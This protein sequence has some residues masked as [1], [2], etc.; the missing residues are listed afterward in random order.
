MMDAKIN[1]RINKWLGWNK[2][3]D[4]VHSDH[5]CWKL[6]ETLT[7][8]GL[9]IHEISAFPAPSDALVQISGSVFY[10]GDDYDIWKLTDEDLPRG[11]TKGDFKLALC[12]AIIDLLDRLDSGKLPK[13]EV[14]TG[15]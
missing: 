1:D 15:N 12:L 3:F 11:K 6:I 5:L 10:N 9:Y 4:V 2:E 14:N 13:S 7:S 8:K